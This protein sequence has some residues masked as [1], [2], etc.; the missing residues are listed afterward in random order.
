LKQKK[1]PS[2]SIEIIDEWR[3]HQQNSYNKRYFYAKISV[4]T[5]KKFTSNWPLVHCFYLTKMRPLSVT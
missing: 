4:V 5:L 3:F 1:S 2:K